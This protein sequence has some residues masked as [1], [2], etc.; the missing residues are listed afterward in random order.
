MTKCCVKEPSISKKR[1]LLKKIK[2]YKREINDDEILN[3]KI[4]YHICY[5]D[6]DENIDKDIKNS[7]D[8]LNKDFNKLSDNFDNGKNIYKKVQLEPLLPMLRMI[9]LIKINRRIRRNRRRYR[10]AILIN[11]KRR[12][13]NKRRKRINKR[14]Q[15]INKQRQK[16]NNSKKRQFDLYSKYTEYVNLAGSCNINF[17]L[18][19]KVV[20]VIEPLLD[21]ELNVLD[22]KLKLQKSPIKYGDE[23]FLHIWVANFDNGLL[24]YAQFPW[25]TN[26][27]TDGVVINTHPFKQSAL[28]SSYNLGKTLTH[29]VGH[30]MGLYHVF[31]QTYLNQ[32]GG[33]DTN[34]DNKLSVGETTGDLIEDTP[35]QL[36]PTYGNVYNNGWSSYKINNV[37]H[38]SMFMNFM[39][40]SDDINLFM[41]TKEQC[42]KIRLLLEMYRKNYLL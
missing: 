7:L 1:E 25:E 16:R 2:S 19:K 40:Y 17:S 23:N 15:Q 36:N 18:E 11:R 3:I 31:Q 28:F 21:D 13:I 37:K 30:W 26:K 10:R 41:F 24:G 29:E 38:Y 20:N 33:I 34:N 32:V 6:T 22:R 8:I 35:P 14:R 42:L 9:R 12:N 39:D 4:V 5:S 27:R